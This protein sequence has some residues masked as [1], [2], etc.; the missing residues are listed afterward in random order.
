MKTS[1]I[2]QLILLLSFPVSSQTSFDVP[3]Q[4]LVA[5]YPFNGN[6]N[7][8]SGN[9]L[10][11]IV[12]GA[13]LNTDRFGIPNSAF[14]FNGTSSIIRFG[15]ILDSVFSAPIAKFTV[16]G[17]AKTKS[18]KTF[19][20]DG[21]F[22]IGKNAGG[23]GPYQW[24]IGHYEGKVFATIFSDTNGV[25][26][27]IGVA[28]P[29]GINQWFHFVYI[30]DGS[31]PELQR[32]KLYINGQ[33]SNTTVLSHVGT[34]GTT[35]VNTHQQFTLGATHARN[36]PLSNSNYYDGTL[37]D[38]RIYNGALNDSAIQSLYHEKGWATS[39]ASARVAFYPLNG[40]AKDSSGNGLNG[41]VAGAIPTADRFGQSNAAYS[42][43]G[44]NSMIR[45]GDI[46]DSVFSTPIAKFSVAGW[47][48]SRTYG[49]FAGGGGFIVGK[50]SGGGAHGPAQWSISH[51]D[52]LIYAAVFSDTVGQNYISL[53]SPTLK[54]KWFHFVLVF[55]GNLPE[56][57]RIKLWVNGSSANT[58]LYQ[59]IGTLGTATTASQQNLTVGAS[60]PGG[61]PLTPENAYDG[62]VDDISIYNFA[63]VDG[64]IQALYHENGW[65]YQIDVPRIVSIKD[66]PN[67]NGK[68]VLIG[69]KVPRPA[70]LNGIS[71]FSVRLWDRT[72]LNWVVVRGDI[73]SYPDTIH[74]TIAT[75]LFDS[76]KSKG[77]Y[78]SVFQIGAHGVTPDIVT[79]SPS[80]SGYSLDNLPPLAPL[81]PAAKPGLSNSWLVSWRPPFGQ[82]GDF[83]NYVIYR[84]TTPNFSLDSSHRLGDVKDTVYTD[85]AVTA[86]TKYY[87]GI[88]A[89]DYSGNESPAAFVSTVLRVKADLAGV[90]DAFELSQ[91]Y[92][93]P[94]NPLTVIRF[95]IPVK[96]RV[97]LEIF[98]ILGERISTL[99]NE[100]VEPGFYEKE[101]AGGV[102][103]GLYIYRIDA[104][105][106][107]NG[108]KYFSTSKKMLMIK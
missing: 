92:P 49:T 81:A 105:S 31:L 30:F 79:I 19:A 101:W 67:D 103:S 46:L 53:T 80:D 71:K 47:A 9:G 10:N 6:A 27:Y 32:L 52:G 16:S 5:Y 70:A 43:N 26:N 58:A 12:S 35:T 77:M 24:G 8:S 20:D 41:I 78:Y 29:I 51:V 86:G 73:D 34:I 62:D 57:Q 13:A 83:K 37:D 64:D 90:P 88:T 23:P 100:D 63:L 76:T 28:S 54:D 102:A 106:T 66:V 22:M 39:S 44:V 55:D 7:D 38:I 91:N 82:L 15:D 21:G 87:Y 40:N 107:V 75:T 98:N 85:N 50:N 11:G 108:S 42:F 45:L 72:N 74:T 36:N 99:L 17:W 95:G 59:H 68:Q 61:N 14:T 4:G 69:W 25:T 1:A 65:A 2:L 93:N 96:S 104:F 56:L 3:T 89:V 33:S 18:Y 94:F 60:H 97:K 48:R 84:S